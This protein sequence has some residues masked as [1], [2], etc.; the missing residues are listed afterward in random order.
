M[1]DQITKLSSWVV[2]SSSLWHKIYHQLY[3][4]GAGVLSLTPFELFDSQHTVPLLQELVL[5]NILEGFEQSEDIDW[6]KQ[7]PG[8]LIGLAGLL[9]WGFESTF[10]VRQHLAL[11]G[12]VAVL[13]ISSQSNAKKPLTQVP[14][15]VSESELCLGLDV[16]SW[17]LLGELVVVTSGLS[18]FWFW[19]VFLDGIT[20]PAGIFSPSKICFETQHFI[21]DEQMPGTSK[22]ASQKPESLSATHTPGH[23][24]MGNKETK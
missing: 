12:H 22:M 2:Q 15:Q 16:G 23:F 17:G 4:F 18:G 19:F 14:E 9:F 13:S 6:G 1:S 7:N 3:L 20:N 10:L 5:C 8:H 11:P 21:L 24:S